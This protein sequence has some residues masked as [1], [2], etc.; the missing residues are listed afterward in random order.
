VEERS[1]EAASTGRGWAGLVLLAG[2]VPLLVHRVGTTDTPADGSPSAAVS[3]KAAPETTPVV[4]AEATASPSG[5][6]T[7]RTPPQASVELP[8]ASAGA[9]TASSHAT[10]RDALGQELARRMPGG[11]VSVWKRDRFGRAEEQRVLTGASSMSAGRDV[12]RRAYAWSGPDEIASIASHDPTSGV[13]R[14]A[15]QYEYDPRGHLIRQLFSSG[16][17]LE[18]ASDPAGNLFRSRDMTDRVYAKGGVL[19]KAGGTTYETDA[20]G[21]LVKKTLSDGATWKYTWDAHGRLSEVA[22]PDGK[23]VRFA[24]DAFGRRVSK[25]F[26]GKTTEYVWDGDDLVHERVRAADG[27]VASPVV[28]WVSEPGAFTPLAKL[29]GRKRWGIVTD[30]LGTPTMLATEAGKI[31]WQAQLDVYGVVREESVTGAGSDAAR[32]SERTSNPWRYP[33]QYEDAETGL[34]YN[35]FRYYDPETGRYLSEDPIGLAGGVASYGYV[36]AP[37]WWVDPFGLACTVQSVHNDFLSKGVHINASNGIE[38]LVRP[39]SGG[40]IVFKKAFASASPT[41]VRD[42]IKEAEHELASNRAF[43]EKLLDAANRGTRWLADNGGA[44]KSAETRFLAKALE[45][46]RP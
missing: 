18:R 7:D 5:V 10:A 44:S 45:K 28:T 25:S 43:R 21:F 36:G 13:V 30:H 42:A 40:V 39:G 22:R 12:A 14:S 1:R 24:Y 8:N 32:E 3:P 29:E 17:I 20:D 35:R 16:E 26:E 11:V 19:Q 9:P 27:T 34:Y 33:G 2:G 38:L 23:V 6:A 31:A 4:T 15:S 37:N 46:L 41:A